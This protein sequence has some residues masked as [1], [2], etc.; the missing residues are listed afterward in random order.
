MLLEQRVEELRKDRRHGAGWMA[1]RAVETLVEA[2]EEETQSSEELLDRLVGVGRELAASRPGVG[3]VEGAVGRLLAA[4]APHTHLSVDEL[5]RLIEE[6]AR[7]LTDARTRAA[8]AIAIQLRGR[9]TDAHVLTHSASATVREALVRSPPEQVVCTVS[10][11]IGEGRAF[12]EDL[13]S[14]GLSVELVED[15]DAKAALAHATLLLV[16]ADTVFRDGTLCNKLGTKELAEAANAEGVPTVV[17]SE[18]IKLAPFD[19][20]SLPESVH[21]LFDLTPPHLIDEIVTEE[22]V[23]QPDE[24]AALVDRTPFLR[25]GYELLRVES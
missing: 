3:A 6:E 24:I 15:E 20:G 19:A 9:L 10:A 25:Q 11:P 18:V 8:A 16:G 7:S 17:A 12:A 14:A 4:A 13:R 5:R 22:G 23:L 1:R 2:S 21:A